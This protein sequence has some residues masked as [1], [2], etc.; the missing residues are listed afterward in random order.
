MKYPTC[1][2]G[3]CIMSDYFRY[4]SGTHPYSWEYLDDI[5]ETQETMFMKYWRIT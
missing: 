4:D 1:T 5:C 3:W 2:K